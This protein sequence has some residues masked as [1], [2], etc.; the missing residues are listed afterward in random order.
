MN[1]TLG[2]G[3]A[4][5]P[6]VR[7]LGPAETS[8]LQNEYVHGD[9]PNGAARRRDYRRWRSAFARVAA[10]A[11]DALE[12]GDRV[13]AIKVMCE[14]VCMEHAIL[15]TGD[16]DAIGVEGLPIARDQWRTPPGMTYQ[17]EDWRPLPRTTEEW[18]GLGMSPPDHVWNFEN[19]HAGDPA[20]LPARDNVAFRREYLGQFVDP[21]PSPFFDV[22]RGIAIDSLLDPP[23]IDTRRRLEPNGRLPHAVSLTGMAPGQ[24]TRFE[25]TRQDQA[26]DLERRADGWHVVGPTRSGDRRPRALDRGIAGWTRRLVNQQTPEPVDDVTHSFLYAW[27]D[28]PSET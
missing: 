18:A 27:A 13:G 7:R 3:S 22:D 12:Q 20:A 8:A 25:F 1:R 24:P 4:R 21:D 28:E 14:V 19:P 15:L 26:I 16:V 9:R 17:L 5:R 2:I 10:V 23:R 11:A 6:G